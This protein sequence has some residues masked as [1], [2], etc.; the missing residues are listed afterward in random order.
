MLLASGLETLVLTPVL[1][2]AVVCLASVGIMKALETISL[3]DCHIRL[4]SLVST[5]LY[6]IPSIML[7]VGAGN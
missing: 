3:A 7:T 1:V 5:A 4:L 6:H 2:L